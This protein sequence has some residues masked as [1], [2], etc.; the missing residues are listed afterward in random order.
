MLTFEV[1]VFKVYLVRVRLAI[2]E[3]EVLVLC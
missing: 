3:V 2:G 1:A